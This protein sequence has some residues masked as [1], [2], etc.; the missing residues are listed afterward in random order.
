MD[1][2]CARAAGVACAVGVAW[3]YRSVDELL[4]TGADIIA[5]APVNILREV[6]RRA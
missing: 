3:G 5:D 6:E 4:G 2:R 1:M